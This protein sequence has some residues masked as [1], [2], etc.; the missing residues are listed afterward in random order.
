M[1]KYTVHLF[2][3]NDCKRPK[4]QGLTAHQHI[5]WASFCKPGYFF[6]PASILPWPKATSLASRGRWNPRITWKIGVRTSV[7]SR[8]EN[9][10]STEY[11]KHCFYFEL[12]SW[13]APEHH[14]RSLKYGLRWRPLAFFS[15]CLVLPT[16]FSSPSFLGNVLSSSKIPGLLISS[17]TPFI[18]LPRLWSVGGWFAGSWSCWT[19]L[20]ERA[21]VLLMFLMKVF[22]SSYG[23]NVRVLCLYIVLFLVLLSW[24]WFGISQLFDT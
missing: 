7:S 16:Y 9:K 4:R 19:W 22:M 17:L 18:L 2:F 14:W 20:F 12:F 6:R 13:R 5:P 15:S 11:L 10:T 21:S 3:S 8:K 24:P 1:R 23:G